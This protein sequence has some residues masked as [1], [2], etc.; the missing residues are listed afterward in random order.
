MRLMVRE[1]RIEDADGVSVL[2]GELDYPS[3]DEAARRHIQ[4]FID[5]PASRLMIAE[6]TDSIIGLIATHIVP[7][8]D[9]D[10]R[11]CRITDIVVLASHRRQGVATRLLE[12]ACDHAI[13]AGAPRLDLSSGE[14]RG[15][16]H[17]FYLAH[18]FESRSRGFTKR[19]D[20]R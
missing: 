15:E 9:S 5:D 10:K 19:L 2:L 14:W 6:G 12:A 13:A 3:T 11:T 4:R 16:A 18:G 8:L 17:G 20:A 1:A 7:R